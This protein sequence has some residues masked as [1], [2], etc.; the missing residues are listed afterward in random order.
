MASVVKVVGAPVACRGGGGVGASTRQ[1]RGAAVASARCAG[2][3]VQASAASATWR[4]SS[5]DAGASLSL[6]DARLRRTGRRGERQLCS[7][8]RAVRGEADPESAD[9]WISNWK[10]GNF[11]RA[12]G[13][14]FGDTFEVGSRAR[15][16]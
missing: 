7:P 8:A 6:G 13:W 11:P 5:S 4:G 12:K 2:V 9:D 3:Q 14:K 1:R 15:G 16:R 10:A